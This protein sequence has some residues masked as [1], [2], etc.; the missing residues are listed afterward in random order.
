MPV[1]VQWD[2]TEQNIVRWEMSGSLDAESF[3]AA[4]DKT[5][6]LTQD[7]TDRLDIIVHLTPDVRL[8]VG[9]IGTL[10]SGERRVQRMGNTNP[11][12]SVVIVAN[13]T[14][15]KAFL[16]LFLKLGYTDRWFSAP[17]LEAAYTRI[18][19]DRAGV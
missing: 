13:S 19:Q 2:D 4:Q 8:P 12:N 14:L 6:E 17:T 10:A 5:F 1:N 9:F 11:S 18:A 3:F 16:D 15:A 7:L